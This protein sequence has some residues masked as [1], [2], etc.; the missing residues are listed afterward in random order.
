MFGAARVR[1]WWRERAEFH[2]W[3]ERTR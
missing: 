2:L 1:Q 3:F